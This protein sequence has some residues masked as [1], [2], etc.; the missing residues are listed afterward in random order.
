M[1]G[2]EREHMDRI[3]KEIQKLEQ[4]RQ[5]LIKELGKRYSQD[6]AKYN[7]SQLTYLQIV[8]DLTEKSKDFDLKKSNE[9]LR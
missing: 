9:W 6:E 7:N 5:N 8:R 4:E 2:E 1:I 3:L